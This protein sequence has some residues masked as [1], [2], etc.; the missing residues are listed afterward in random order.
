M[1]I[2]GK[3]G[4]S[5]EAPERPTIVFLVGFGSAKQIKFVERVGRT[6]FKP[7]YGTNQWGWEGSRNAVITVKCS[8]PPCDQNGICVE[9][10]LLSQ[11]K[12]TCGSPKMSFIPF[13][14]TWIHR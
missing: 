11:V 7:L 13:E 2:I 1:V 4:N 10:N 12:K 8:A 6:K 14:P 9:A 3:I 5:T